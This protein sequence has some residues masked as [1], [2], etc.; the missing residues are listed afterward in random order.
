MIK[1]DNDGIHVKLAG[2]NQKEFNLL[3]S[4]YSAATNFSTACR[5]LMT[6][7]LV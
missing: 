3:S 7:D 1:K 6:Y 5:R 4:A 2:F